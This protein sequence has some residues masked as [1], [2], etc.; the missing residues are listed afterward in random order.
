MLNF[1]LRNYV[2]TQKEKK[3]MGQ[4][5]DVHMNDLKIIPTMIQDISE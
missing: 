2:H 5:M 3:H 4:I 1:S